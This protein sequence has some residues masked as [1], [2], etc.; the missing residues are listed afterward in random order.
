VIRKLGRC[1]FHSTRRRGELLGSASRGDLPFDLGAGAAPGYPGEDQ[2]NI[3][4]LPASLAGA[5]IVKI[6]VTAS[7][8]AANPVNVLIK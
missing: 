7:L 4:P 6:V 1:T 8:Q 5:G 3:G 2:V